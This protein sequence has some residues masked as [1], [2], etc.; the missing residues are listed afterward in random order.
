MAELWPGGPVELPHEFTLDDHVLTIPQIDTPTLF[1]WLANGAWWQILPESVDT[2][3]LMP[4][5]LRFIS[6]HD[7]FDYEHLWEPATAIFAA[8]AG[9]RPR[10]GVGTGWWPAVRLA[11]SASVNWLVYTGWCAAHG[12]RPLEGPLWQVI[13][14]IYGWLRDGRAG[15]PDELAKLDQAIWAPPPVTSAAPTEELPRHVRDEEAAFALAA[16]HESLPGEIRETEWTPP[17]HD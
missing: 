9:T 2:V 8:L 7:E 11:A 13:G 4:F 5:S 3:R 10:D 16:L 15:N 14:G 6:D 17:P 12:T 1:G